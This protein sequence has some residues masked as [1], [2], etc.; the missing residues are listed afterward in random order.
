MLV[1]TTLSPR[2]AVTFLMRTPKLEVA[3]L[4]LDG[5]WSTRGFKQ[6]TEWIRGA[7]FY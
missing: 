4:G 6:L 3:A 5:S 1:N 2:D 7:Q